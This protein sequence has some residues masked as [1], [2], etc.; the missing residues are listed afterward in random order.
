MKRLMG[1][2]TLSLL[3]ASCGG[4]GGSD[5]S[6]GST[7]SEP[8]TTTVTSSSEEETTQKAVL[9]TVE[10]SLVKGAT[11]CVKDTSVCAETDDSGKA[12]LAVTALPVSL[13]VKV[14]SL[15]LGELTVSAD[16]A[17]L[18]PML[19][20]KGDLPA[21]LALAGVLHGTAGDKEGTAEKI[22]LS[23]V[24]IVPEEEISGSL[25]D[26]LKEKKEVRLKVEKE[27]KVS[28]V[29]VKV[30]DDG[31]VEV[32]VDGEKVN[33][34]GDEVKLLLW[35]VSTF[36]TAADGKTIR[37]K[38]P[39]GEIVSC[40][41]EVNPTNPNQFKLQECTN[42]EFND[43]GYE[44]IAVEDGKV[45]VKDE[46]GEK[47][48]V[49]DVSVASFTAVLKNEEGEQELV[50][51]AEAPSIVP[52]LTT[53]EARE[54]LIE[55]KFDLVY[56]YLSSKDN[57]AD[58]E[59]VLF[60]LAVLGKAAKDNL[61][62]PVGM[63]VVTS[64]EGTCEVKEVEDGKVKLEAL[65]VGAENFLNGINEAIK[66]L[67]EVKEPESVEIAEEGSSLSLDAPS[68]K[69]LQAL[70]Y[71]A[72][73]NLEYLLAYDWGALE[74]PAEKKALALELLTYLKLSDSTYLEKSRSDLK[75]AIS[76]L[77]SAGNEL[78]SLPC[79]DASTVSCQL[80]KEVEE[81]E[82]FSKETLSKLVE[83]LQELSGAPDGKVDFQFI[84][85]KTGKVN[86][87]HLNLAHLF[88]EPLTGEEVKR[89]V[90]NKDLIQVK[91]CTEYYWDGE[92]E[93][94]YEFDYDILFTKDSSIYKRL[95]ASEWEYF[96]SDLKPV[97]G[98][99]NGKNY[100]SLFGYDI[101]TDD[102]LEVVYPKEQ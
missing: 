63:A 23:G 78:L 60:A 90:E 66:Q 28:E 7:T 29:E 81:E 71:Y 91:I 3:I 84:S 25:V 96:E 75:S 93:Y 46:D 40:S 33:P 13:E 2:L 35:K 4:G 17:R 83:G 45:V 58:E 54:K 67:E 82:S 20:A 72:K 74:E 42:P 61:L 9:A 55:G 70:L 57:L 14:G 59:K 98:T 37:L 85:F 68:L 12:Q 36:L 32:T 18:N 65:Q 79:D 47:F 39:E 16:V 48:S 34:V 11:V 43:D 6:T 56:S 1:A 22:D 89:D 21:A 100:Y 64:V 49:E 5:Y 76:T 69:A 102:I 27:G 24:E 53:E 10:A 95:E 99:L 15:K 94:C 52:E 8:V 51:L 87:Y 44:T 77:A 97:E 62:V 50:W 73:S 30:S 88:D 19:L 26:T 80:L 38:T 31:S 101:S 41:L 86:D 92:E